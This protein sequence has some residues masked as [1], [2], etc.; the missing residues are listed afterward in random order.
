DISRLANFGTKTTLGF[1]MFAS[2]LSIPKFAGDRYEDAANFGI[3]TLGKLSLPGRERKEFWAL[4]GGNFACAID[5]A[6]RGFRTAQAT[7]LAREPKLG[8]SGIAI[9]GEHLEHR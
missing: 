6:S 9:R 3:G 8:D 1:N 4:A 5:R 7:R 2:V